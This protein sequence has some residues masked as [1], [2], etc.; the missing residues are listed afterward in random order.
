[1]SE[2]DGLYQSAASDGEESREQLV[3]KIEVR[4]YDSPRSIMIV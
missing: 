1:M 2:L 4:V 3:K